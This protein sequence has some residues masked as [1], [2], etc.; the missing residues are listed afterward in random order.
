MRLQYGI[1]AFKRAR[2]DLAELPV[3]NMYAEEA[4]SEESG[5]VLQSRPGLADRSADMGAGPIRALFKADGVL[6]GALFG[7]SGASLY[8]AVTSV[9]T[10]SGDGPF[11]IAGYEDRIFV[12][13]GGSLYTYDGTTLST[14]SF[15]DAANVTK[16]VVGASRLLAIRADTEQFYWSDVLSTTID[17]LSFSSAESQPDR[18]RDILFIDDIA[19][20]FGAETVEFHANTGDADLPF[21]PIEGRVMERGIKNT[22][23]ASRLGS[24]FAWVTNNNEVC[25]GDQDNVVSAPGLQ[26]LI[27]ASA[28]AY[29]FS[30]FIDGAEFLAMRIDSGT[31]VYCPRTGT[32]SQFASHDEDNWIIQC[33]AGGVFG[34]ALDGKTYAW[35]AHVDD[36]S[37]LERRFR[38]G[39]VLNGGAFAMGNISLRCNVGQTVFLTGDYTDPQVEMRLSRNA[40]KTWG[41]WRSTTLGVQGNYDKPVRWPGLGLA[42]RPGI[43]AEFRVTAP[44]DWR[45]SDVLVNEPYGGF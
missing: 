23:A 13:G 45:V 20:L 8:Q 35:G 3:I 11:A 30:F 5:V 12:S 19:I 17:A 16:A 27:E 32:F 14:V 6:S 34:S 39:M 29:L 2:G 22:G 36:G 1:S 38:A 10:V 44:V 21:S 37:V 40:G 28:A 4:A 7:V 18:L 41:E 43:L 24:S 15:P 9:G 26:A 25:I 33:H 31:W 42:S